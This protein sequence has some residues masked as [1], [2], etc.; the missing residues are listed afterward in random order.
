MG[1]RKIWWNYTKEGLD[2]VTKTLPWS[3]IKKYAKDE[4]RAPMRQILTFK[5][6]ESATTVFLPVVVERYR[7][8]IR[9]KRLDFDLWGYLE[10]MP[11]NNFRI[12]NGFNYIEFFKT[13]PK[14]KQDK[15][16]TLS[17]N[18]IRILLFGK[19]PTFR[20]LLLEARY[21]IDTLDDAKKVEMF[22]RW[23]TNTNQ[24]TVLQKT[25]LELVGPL[26]AIPKEA[27]DILL[28]ITLKVIELNTRKLSTLQYMFEDHDESFVNSLRDFSSKDQVYLIKKLLKCLDLENINHQTMYS[29]I[30][31]HALSILTPDK[32]YELVKSH[33]EGNLV[34]G[35]SSL[36][37]I[38]LDELI[39]WNDNPV[40][41][42]NIVLYFTAF[43]HLVDKVPLQRTSNSRHHILYERLM[44]Y[45]R[46]FS[47]YYELPEDGYH[48]KK[49]TDVLNRLAGHMIY[50][51]EKCIGHWED[52]SG[53]MDWVLYIEH[54]KKPESSSPTQVASSEVEGGLLLFLLLE[55]RLTDQPDESD[56]SKWFELFHKAMLGS[57]FDDVEGISRVEQSWLLTKIK[58]AVLAR[59]S[60]RMI[61]YRDRNV[62]IEAFFPGSDFIPSSVT[63]IA[64]IVVCRILENKYFFENESESDY[65]SL[66]KEISTQLLRN[67]YVYDFLKFIDLLQ[68]T[69]IGIDFKKNLI[70]EL[71]GVISSNHQCFDLIQYSH[72]LSNVLEPTHFDNRST[73]ESILT[74]ENFIRAW[75]FHPNC[76]ND[77]RWY[78]HLRGPWRNPSSRWRSYS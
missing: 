6:L 22:D 23:Q 78:V 13:L 57:T 77:R 72:L 1:R 52:F 33:F 32:S 26:A 11:E 20:S 48:S 10:A 64:M 61:K 9:N 47:Q 12:E 7:R 37:L 41:E 45:I 54:V 39:T 28:H 4:T 2:S 25:L 69:N 55:E 58:Q 63:N 18:N 73:R 38:I 46:P 40:P 27:K 16:I 51:P 50:Q 74:N 66:V 36:D 35:G 31:T 19:T 42:G 3:E 56:Y 71:V 49:V 59:F 8:W 62:F 5:E 53:W 21:S 15:I 24:Q 43:E 60:S 30:L 44:K 14:P 65:I 29:S 34:Q 75:E 70:D 67:D 76:K 17:F 68:T